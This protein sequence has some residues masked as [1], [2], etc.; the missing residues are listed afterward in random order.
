MNQCEDQDH[1]HCHYSDLRKHQTL[2]FLQHQQLR[3]ALAATLSQKEPL[4][5]SFYKLTGCHGANAKQCR[6]L[7][8]P[9][10]RMD[11]Y[12]TLLLHLVIHVSR[13]AQGCMVW[14]TCGGQ[15]TTLA[16]WFSPSIWQAPG[17]KNYLRE[18]AKRTFKS[19]IKINLF[20]MVLRYQNMSIC[21]YV[22][23]YAHGICMHTGSHA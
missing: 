21:M 2:Q 5:V 3:E 23:V 9:N 12:V 4:P 14:C 7:C 11:N 16:N 17:I 22:H 15:R 6:V 1:C 19:I 10:N 18:M 20:Q 13:R 8:H